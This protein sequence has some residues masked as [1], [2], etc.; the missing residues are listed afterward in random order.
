VLAPAGA[1]IATPE[2]SADRHDSADAGNAEDQPW[3]ESLQLIGG[4]RPVAPIRASVNQGAAPDRLDDDA[5]RPGRDEPRHS[6]PDTADNS[7]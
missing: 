4:P 7:N 6:E 2:H 3:P 1:V 5:A